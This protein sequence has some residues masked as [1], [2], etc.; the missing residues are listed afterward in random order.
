MEKIKI[1]IADDH[2]LMRSGIKSVLQNDPQVEVTGEA[3]DGT[4][5][6]KLLE[7][8][9]Y[10]IA[11]IDMKMPG[12]SGLEILRRI[13]KTKSKVRFVFLTMYKD[14]EMFNEAMD[15]GAAGYVL[16]ENAADDV[17]ESVKAAAKGEYYI[18]P[19]I[20][21]FL[22]KRLNKRNIAETGT[23]SINNLTA[24]ERVILKLVSEE[25]TSQQIADHLFIS[26][27]TVENHRNNISKKLGLSGTHSLL[28]FALTNK[29]I[30]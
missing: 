25:N 10:D 7:S 26:S 16:K 30:L 8:N 24:T 5:A 21:G 12:L 18:S 4:E 3:S 19:L 20:S 29:N 28:K 14:E 27:K 1:L 13:S 6:I 2:P 23:P 15:A 22:V 9:N 11:L 17:L